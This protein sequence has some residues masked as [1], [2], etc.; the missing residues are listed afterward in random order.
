MD[1]TVEFPDRELSAS[2]KHGVVFK[3]PDA[4]TLVRPGTADS[5]GPRR[6]FR[7]LSAKSPSLDVPSRIVPTKTKAIRPWSAHARTRPDSGHTRKL[8][9]QTLKKPHFKA[10]PR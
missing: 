6:Y 8:S 5:D 9:R 4:E 10:P 3:I 7:P 1:A 2:P